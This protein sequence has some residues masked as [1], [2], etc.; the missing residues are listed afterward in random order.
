MNAQRFTQETEA[1]RTNAHVTVNEKV[2]RCLA[3]DLMDIDI[4]SIGFITQ[5]D[6]HW[7]DCG[8]AAGVLGDDRF[9][10]IGAAVDQDKNV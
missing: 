4:P 3:C 1:G 7:M 2:D 9:R 6:D 8:V 10:T 5:C